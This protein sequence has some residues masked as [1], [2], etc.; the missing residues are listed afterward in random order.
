MYPVIGYLADWTSGNYLPTDHCS[1]TFCWILLSQKR[2][3]FPWTVSDQN[4]WFA[5]GFPKSKPDPVIIVEEHAAGKTWRL[6]DRGHWDLYCS[7]RGVRVY[8]H[9][10]VHIHTL[11]MAM[12]CH[13][14]AMKKG[15]ISSVGKAQQQKGS[16]QIR[17]GAS[18]VGHRSQ[19]RL[20]YLS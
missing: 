16:F 9:T 5:W 4:I 14:N 3:S 8:I 6:H 2:K 17:K 20:E 7:R 15:S 18:L 11:K 19:E 13:E 12:K 1:L 10:Y